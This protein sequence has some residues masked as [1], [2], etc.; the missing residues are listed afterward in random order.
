MPSSV[1]A[2]GS[3]KAVATLGWVWWKAVSK[4][5]TCGSV[6]MQLR[7]R[8]D[9]GEVMR[10]MQRRQRNE[11]R[12]LGDDRGI[13]ANRRGIARSAMH[14]AMAGRDQLAGPESALS[15]QRR[16]AAKRIL[17]GRAPSASCSSTSALP[18]RSFAVKCT[19]CPMPSHCAFANQIAPA[20]PLIAGKE[21][22]LDARRAGVEDEDGVAHGCTFRR[23]ARQQQ[24]DGAGA[25]PCQRLVGA[26]GQDDRH[27]RAQHDA[28]DL[29][30]GE[31]FE[32]LG[33][34]VA[35]LEVGHDE[36]VGLPGDRRDDALGLGG[37]LRDR[38]V[39]GQRAVEDAAG[40]LA[41][42]GHLAQRGGIERGLDLLGNGL[43]R[44]QDRHAAAASMPSACA[45]S[46]A[47]C[48]MSRLSSS[49]G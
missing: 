47:F 8:R 6:G 17:M 28:G 11:R 44:R 12:Q 9:G 42:V 2:R 18:A 24:R 49:V 39:E 29:G 5:A 14:H 40:D 7:Q 32:L 33:Q 30:L 13:D 37:L 16:S 43:D 10:L 27:A 22:E 31:I 15:S 34:H 23:V 3:A 38:I 48:T 36:D 4:Q 41:A 26:A 25:E 21:R 35:G 20:R 46:I 45:R 1:R 19:R